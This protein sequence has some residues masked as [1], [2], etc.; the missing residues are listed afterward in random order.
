MCRPVTTTTKQLTCQ[1]RLYAKFWKS[2][3]P[4]FV[5]LS[6]CGQ[7]EGKESRTL[8]RG[9]ASLYFNVIRVESMTSGGKSV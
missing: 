9:E 3:C 1:V 7:C 5:D 4:L 6:D 8:L 2:V